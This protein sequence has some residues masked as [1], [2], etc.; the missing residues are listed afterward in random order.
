MGNGKL[1]YF[2]MLFLC[3]AVLMIVVAWSRRSMLEGFAGQQQP[4][5]SWTNLAYNATT[6]GSG[7]A[8]GVSIGSDNTIMCLNNQD[9]IAKSVGSRWKVVP[10]VLKEIHVKDVDNVIGIARDFAIYKTN[11]ASA[12]SVDW[13]KLSASRFDSV[14]LGWDGSV[15]ATT[16]PI[17][18]TWEA[19]VY[20]SS[21]NAWTKLPGS[22]SQVSVLSASI[23]WGLDAQGA[24]WKWSRQQWSQ[25]P[26]KFSKI[27]VGVDGAVWAMDASGVISRFSTVANSWQSISG[28]FADFSAKD[29]NTIAVVDGNGNVSVGSLASAGPVAMQ[30]A[31]PFVMSAYSGGSTAYSDFQQSAVAWAQL[32]VNGNALLG[33]SN[34]G[35][36]YNVLALDGRGTMV[37]MKSYDVNQSPVMGTQ[38]AHDLAPMLTNKTTS[39]SANLYG[40]YT[41]GQSGSKNF[42][43]AVN[44]HLIYTGQTTDGYYPANVVPTTYLLTFKYKGA[45]PFS[46]SQ[47]GI[48][49]GNVGETLTGTS[50]W[51]V[52]T[53]QIV[54]TKTGLHKLSFQNLEVAQTEIEHP[55]LKAVS[56]SKASDVMMVVVLGQGNLGTSNPDIVSFFKSLGSTSIDN[57]TN[58]TSY[59]FIYNA[60]TGS[61]INEQFSSSGHVLFQSDGP[62][63]VLKSTWSA[64]ASSGTTTSSIIYIINQGVFV[65]YDMNTAAV[66]TTTNLSATSL[67]APF[68]SGI[69]SVYPMSDGTTY[70]MTRGKLWLTT[71]DLKAFT[72]KD[73]PGVI[74]QGL[75]S[76][77]NKAPF[78][79]GI[80]AITPSP[81]NNAYAFSFNTFAKL[82]ASLTQT[83]ATGALGA[84][85]T[86]FAGLPAAFQNKID[87]AFLAGPNIGLIAGDKLLYYDPK[88]MM[89]ASGPTSILSN[90]QFLGLPLSFKESASN[91]AKPFFNLTTF[92]GN[93]MKNFDISVQTGQGYPGWDV[94]SFQKFNQNVAY[95]VVDPPIR[96]ND[97]LSQ[98]PDVAATYGTDTNA[99]LKA[100][101]SND[102]RWSGVQTYG[103]N[104]VSFTLVDPT[105]TSY[106]LS[107]SNSSGTAFNNAEMKP[108][109][110]YQLSLWVRTGDPT[111]LTVGAESGTPSDAGVALSGIPVRSA[112][113]WQLLTWSFYNPANA[114]AKDISFTLTQ[115]TNRSNVIHSLYGPV[116]LTTA[117]LLTPHIMSKVDEADHVY[118]NAGGK[119]LTYDGTNLTFTSSATADSK[120]SLY[121]V[122]DSIVVTSATRYTSDGQ[123]LNLVSDGKSCSFSNVQ[124]SSTLWVCIEDDNDNSF[125]V[126]RATDTMLQTGSD[127]NPTVAVCKDTID[128][129]TAF[130]FSLDPPDPA[131]TTAVYV[132][133]AFSQP[134]SVVLIRGNVFTCYDTRKQASVI[135][136][137]KLNEHSWFMKLPEGSTKI[138]SALQQSATT[139][140]FNGRR[141]CAWSLTSNSKGP[142]RLLLGPGGDA[143]F[144]KMPPPFSKHLDG[145]FN[146]DASSAV[147]VSKGMWLRWDV[148][149]NV[150]VAYGSMSS[151]SSMF[152]GF[153]ASLLSAGIDS[154]VENPN[155]MGSAYF[156]SSGEYILYDCL[157]QSTLDGPNALGSP[158]TPFANL[159][160]PFIPSEADMCNLYLQNVRANTDYPKTACVD[161]P[162][163]PY[164]WMSDCM[165]SD[166]S[167]ETAGGVW[168]DV[169]GFCGSAISKGATPLRNVDPSKRNSNLANYMRSCKPVSQYDYDSMTGAEQKKYDALNQRL[170]K[171]KADALRLAARVSAEQKNLQTLNAA[172]SSLQLKLTSEDA[173]ACRPNFVCLKSIGSGGVKDIPL[174]CEQKT[175]KQ[176]LAKN[177]MTDAD[178]QALLQLLT[179]KGAIND[180][181][182]MQHPDYPNLVPTGVVTKCTPPKDKV[183]TDFPL[184]DF[185]DFPKYIRKDQILSNQVP[186]GTTSSATSGNP[187]GG[188]TQNGTSPT[189]SNT[190]SATNA[191]SKIQAGS[192]GLSSNAGD[193]KCHHGKFS[194]IIRQALSGIQGN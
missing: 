140:L 172:L 48:D 11:N 78:T 15:W 187:I 81:D 123:P 150:P 156:F 21:T 66:K 43:V 33:A 166:V 102:G 159:T 106:W 193:R 116:L 145:A 97:F 191:L 124:D 19:Y 99:L 39:A 16:L 110:F 65:Q 79:N 28:T 71:S 129:S 72:V 64:S 96:V 87:S 17:G 179:K 52:Y 125:F 50:D 128:A 108:C 89:V 9:A 146:L 95:N 77:I 105:Q 54:H 88:K 133:A 47:T 38:L 68:N 32:T 41:G 58:N 151:G 182:I 80:Q 174:G 6:G 138:T 83:L 147:F 1:R 135:Y 75:L 40:G 93:R 91:I 137:I 168:N 90:P 20:D 194:S 161:D 67:P 113:G 98:Y 46:I 94:S 158:S 61:V 74:G 13:T 141:F 10:G 73:G 31:T 26:G 121:S 35:N 122:G 119:Y 157:K 117:R 163:R 189:P 56:A 14:S 132:D 190:N 185:P 130:T 127:G 24:V 2:Y 112:D 12:A 183:I 76:G 8:V 154:C 101:E 85:G 18:G 84:K 3:F 170:S 70:L 136:P 164:Q 118:L 104:T 134:S 69:D 51:R 152:S 148:T 143:R 86:D 181:P 55:T 167:C 25:Q 139:Y 192:E 153:D 180:Y 160:A 111:G 57:V 184:K 62:V 59:L 60:K 36:G 44:D 178:I 131:K 186:R 165:F 176:I 4:I 120:M 63:P 114:T 155:Q 30:Q 49:S 53:K 29:A 7:K 100:Y 82:N 23:A 188:Q 27:S 5:L 142:C 177:P 115:S 42:S 173:Q 109:E 37:F 175:I 103:G 92:P 45:G 34:S 107:Y 22:I 144:S 169:G 126:H 162:K 171:E 149:K